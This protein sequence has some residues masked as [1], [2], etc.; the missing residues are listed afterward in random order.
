[1]FMDLFAD[2]WSQTTLGAPLV[3][4]DTDLVFLVW[5]VPGTGI[6]WATD[7]FSFENNKI[8]FQN[9]ALDY[10]R[11]EN[12][13][14][15]TSTQEAWDN[16]FAAF[17]S[18]TLDQIM[19]D[20]T[21]ESVAVVYDVN[22]AANPN[23]TATTY[24]GISEIRGMFAYFFSV[25]TDLTSLNAQPVVDDNM[26]FLLWEC[27]SSGIYQA[28]DS[29]VFDAN[30][31]VKY[32][33]IVINTGTDRRRLADYNS[34]RLADYNPANS[35]EA[36]DNHFAAFGAQDVDKIMLDY[37]DNSEVRVF[38]FADPKSLVDTPI[39]V[40]N[41]TAAIRTMFV[42]LFADI[43]SQ[44]TLGA[45][46]VYQDTDL[47][48]LVWE[49]PGTGI[50]WATDSFSFENNKIRFQNIALDYTRIENPY[51]PTSTQEAWDNH[52]AAFGSQTLDQ[53]MWDYTEE[54]VAVVYDVNDAA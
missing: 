5:E 50:K 20:Y 54:S 18:Q 2:I 8:R 42:D 27:P 36:W 31:K 45:P 28:T 53:I 1:M 14:A 38:N 41:T 10:T 15:P 37:D 21:E 7:S 22:D 6:K 40:Y 44:T 13:Y 9:I 43:W 19:W 24:T 30:H 26:V 29:F 25:L 34:R 46:L 32:Q 48:F 39:A 17:G 4:Q 16:H 3:Y 35:S 51:A 49:V 33:D 12:P 11:I 23:R 47:V 52:F